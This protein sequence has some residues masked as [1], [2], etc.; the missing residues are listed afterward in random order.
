MLQM[1]VVIE[2]IRPTWISKSKYMIEPIYF[3]WKRTHAMIGRSI[4]NQT[5]LLL[6]VQEFYVKISL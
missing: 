3:L 5:V 6:F 1:V 2:L 4:R